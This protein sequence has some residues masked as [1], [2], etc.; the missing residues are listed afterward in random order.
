MPKPEN[1]ALQVSELMVDPN[2]QRTCDYGRAQKI[3][4]ELDM[5]A[6]GIIT[7]SRRP[8]GFNHIVDGQH[9]VEGVR[10]ARGDEQR[11]P[12]RIHFGLTR[13]E[14]ARL[15]RLLNNTARPTAIDK[16]R[17]R[18]VEGEPVAV[19]I[20][21]VL[22]VHGWKVEGSPVEGSFASVVAI[23]RVWRREPDAVE[24]TIATITNAWGRTTKGSN[25][26]IVEGIGLVYARFGDA[27]DDFA[28]ADKLSRFGGKS[29][30]DIADRP[31]RLIGAARGIAETYGW[32][33][34]KGV[35]DL[36]VETYNKGRTTRA[37]P[38]WRDS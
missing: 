12:C 18:V 26:G 7:V 25:G 9:R 22:G 36:V 30:R 4:D 32:P 28:L 16:F 31:A 24:R 13:E 14:E 21:E 2:V 33:V 17:I 3:A 35:A 8:N 5:D 6:L 1:R 19:A 15:F 23:E 38:A 27:V 11:V 10:L 37:L 20:S 34:S 29:A